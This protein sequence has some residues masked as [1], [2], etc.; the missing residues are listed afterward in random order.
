MKE[1]TLRLKT[2]F[3]AVML[4]LMLCG[5]GVTK[6]SA[7]AQDSRA[8]I[9]FADVLVK[10]MCVDNWD[11]NGDGEISYE[12]AAAVTTMGNVFQ[13]TVITSFDELQY[14]TGL[15]S[16][17][18]LG[19]DMLTSIRLPTSITSIGYAAFYGCIRLTSI[20]IPNSVTSIGALAFGNCGGL[21]SINIPNLVTSIGEQAFENCT[22]ITSIEIPNSVTNIGQSAF[23]NCTS[24]TYVKLSNSINYIRNNTFYHCI[25]LTSIEIPNSVGV[26]YNQ[27]FSRCSGLISIDIPAS[28]YNIKDYVF[29]YCNNLTSV[30]IR[31][32]YLLMGIGTFSNCTSLTSITILATTPPELTNNSTFEY[33]NKTI[34][35]YVPLAS[36]NTYKSASYWSEF[37]RYIGVVSNTFNGTIS[38]LWNNISNWSSS[39]LP[40][41]N[42]IVTIE[43]DVIANVD[44]I[45]HSLILAEDVSLTINSGHTLTITGA[46][47]QST[48]SNIIIEDGGQLVNATSG[49]T[50]TVKKNITQWTTS[51]DNGWHAISTPVNNVPFGDVTNI[52]SSDY[53]IYRLNETTMT[54]ENSQYSG[55]T[56]TSFSNGRGYLYRKGDNTAIEFNGTLITTSATYQLSYTSTGFHL[57]GNPYPH[58][59]YKGTNAAIPNTYLEDGFYTLTSAGGWV[60]GTDNTTAIA[61]CQAVLVQA[62]SSV[63][64]EDLIITKT[65][66]TG[67]SK[68][69][70]DNIMFVVSNSNYEDVAY[71]LFKDGH[72]LNKIDHR[73]ADIQKLYIQH[74]GEDFAIANIGEDVQAFNLNFHATTTGKYTLNVKADGNFSYLHLI[75]N[76]TGADIDLLLENVYSFIGASSDKD[77]RFIVK[78]KY[79]STANDD[80]VFA[81]Q[82]GNEIVVNGEGNL[83]IYDVLGRYVMN[84]EINGVE[85]VDVS[86]LQ[87]GVYI[88]RMTGNS[89]K[90]QKVVVK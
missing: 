19:C 1:K 37:K 47:T 21:T 43:S 72:G 25:G 87:T 71:A 53:N 68:S 78:L 28:V 9:T 14:F 46:I 49:I 5:V 6:E 67:S 70:D 86:S 66:A 33:V 55:N 73:N 85:T 40:T 18:F 59:I 76:L 26:I 3:R 64:D 27:A 41:S 22:G 90:T 48:G 31:G 2:A 83:Q 88:L 10:S 82:N 45:A 54:W 60:A 51:P 11:T 4:I 15:T 56:F 62:K 32:T 80:E 79:A 63:T 69:N 20:E 50:A 57:I 74:N 84:R 75:D 30:I 52:T 42:T 38:A 17:T 61:P 34:P 23:S 58:N 29:S 7:I 24:L 12:E 36:V 44:A 81:Y 89:I 77:N 39:S 13:N 65:T 35:V 8:N 16:I